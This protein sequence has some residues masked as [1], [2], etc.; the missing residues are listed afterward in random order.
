MGIAESI[1]RGA[2]SSDPGALISQFHSA[3]PRRLVLMPTTVMAAFLS[4]LNT[5]EAMQVQGA[6][7]D[8]TAMFTHYLLPDQNP[9]PPA[10][11]LVDVFAKINTNSGDWNQIQYKVKGDEILVQTDNELFIQELA[12]NEFNASAHEGYLS[13]LF[14]KKRS[15]CQHGA[16]KT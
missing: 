5:Q 2:F 3:V 10:V 14:Q 12:A 8:W 15:L 7:R 9:L 1:D 6:L 16:R 11:F 4:S 13:A